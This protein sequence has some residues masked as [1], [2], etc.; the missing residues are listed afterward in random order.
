MS[1]IYKGGYA[2]DRIAVTFDSRYRYEGTVNSPTF[3]LNESITRV[4][5]IKID[6]VEMLC[7]FFTFRGANNVL[8]NSNIGGGPITI[9]AGTYTPTTLAAALQTAFR[10]AAVGLAVSTVTYDSTLGKYFFKSNSVTTF[11]LSANSE[12]AA[13][14]GITSDKTSTTSTLSDTAVFETNIVLSG[15]NRTFSFATNGS[16]WTYTIP[17]GNYDGYSLATKLQE[18]ILEKELGYTVTYNA[19]NY[20]FTF[21]HATNTF[22]FYGT[23]SAAAAALGFVSDVSNTGTTLSS[24]Q[25]IS[26]TGPTSI[27]IKSTAITAV[28]QFVVYPNIVYKDMIY[29]L[30]LDGSAGSIIFDKP[31]EPNEIVIASSTG[32][33]FSSIDFRLIDDTGKPI[34]LGPTGRW[35]IY[36]IFE[37]Y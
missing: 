20:T 1:Q 5:R 16:P 13:I 34:S 4:G 18:I 9:T 6:R 29:E 24:E 36:L 12:F 26:I 10:N 8:T 35:K 27:I 3:H 11:S 19:Y 30:S 31:Q 23:T 21:Y 7:S 28:R 15:D 32:A 22:T 17:T 14:L 33:T 2:R 25:A 37:T